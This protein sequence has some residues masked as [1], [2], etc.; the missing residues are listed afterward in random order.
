MHVFV[1]I[2]D[3][4][5]FK[6]HR[7]RL[8]TDLLPR[9]HRVTVVCGFPDAA[10]L[11]SLSTED[12]PYHI[13]PVVLD[14][15]RL[16]LFWDITL[17][18]KVF[19]LLRRE[20]PDALH[21]I[22]IKPILLGGIAMTLA[23]LL[24]VRTGLVWTF[25]GLGKIFEP[26]TSRLAHLQRA[27]AVSVLRLTGAICA[28]WTTTENAA[29]LEE[30]R[31]LGIAKADRS[32]VVFGTGIDLLL[33]SP[34]A[35][36]R[37]S[38]DEPLTFILA[39]RLIRKKGVQAYVDAARRARNG[40]ANA[41]F[42]LAGLWDPGNPD[43]VDRERIE[44]AHREGII[45]FLGPVPQ[46]D[47]PAKLRE[48]DVFCL[49]TLLREGFSRALLEAAS[50][51]L[52]LIASDQPPMRTLIKPGETGWLLDTKTDKATT[53]ALH[54]AIVSACAN[55]LATRQKGS[56]A[57][58]LTCSLPVSADTVC[59]AFVSIYRRSNS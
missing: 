23:R 21:C 47:M 57:R 10:A 56:A 33:F 31:R 17:A 45:E 50:C 9:G 8:V 22:T 43:T 44:Q 53:D 34:T 2:N 4:D 52:A 12:L 13:V 29:D 3:F 48:A 41:R 15:H 55:P 25:A 27:I 38:L 6:A 14:R 49:P 5:Y 58:A 39:A 42:L 26:T 40:G 24:R 18:R 28:P 37:Q 19:S 20:K 7:E 32:E 16:N 1:L 59:D 30:I 36:D 11:A 46:A 51:G 54:D 35:S